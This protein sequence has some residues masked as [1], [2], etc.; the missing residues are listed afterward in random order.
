MTSDANFCRDTGKDYGLDSFLSVLDMSSLAEKLRDHGVT[1]LDA[2]LRLDDGELERA[3]VMQ[4]GVRSRLL[5][6]ILRAHQLPWQ[7]SSV[8]D[9]SFKQVLT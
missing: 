5:A 2:L 3:G 7:K 9:L 8:V 1:T 6:A 4:V